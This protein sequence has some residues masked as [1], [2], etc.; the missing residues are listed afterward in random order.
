MDED[1]NRFIIVSRART[2]STMLRWMLN[3]HPDVCCHGEIFSAE[4]LEG[5]LMNVRNRQDTRV[6]PAAVSAKLEQP[7][8]FLERFA[9]ERGSF[10]AVGV[11]TL[12]HDLEQYADGYVLDALRSNRDIRIIHL[13]RVNR[14]KRYISN[15][16]ASDI[17]KVAV[18]FEDQERPAVRPIV[19]SPEECIRDIAATGRA[20]ERFRGYFRDREVLEVTYEQLVVDKQ[21]A[22]SQ[23]QQFLGVLPIDL[24][25]RTI[26][27]NPDSLRDLIENYDEVS[28]ALCRA[29]YGHYLNS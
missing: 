1:K 18:A 8:D 9:F 2:G 13:T 23:I 26:K 25:P 27:L 10:R 19:L 16:I 14:L 20:E 28:D 11:K 22:G 15:C 7:V 17:T 21:G 5:R 6:A 29:G 3:S 24:Q 12:Y 4:P